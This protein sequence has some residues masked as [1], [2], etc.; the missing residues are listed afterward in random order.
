MKL[1]KI[2]K[3]LPN[4]T[5]ESKGSQILTSRSEKQKDNRKER[6]IQN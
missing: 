2:D 4:N 1:G 3:T 5:D 6:S